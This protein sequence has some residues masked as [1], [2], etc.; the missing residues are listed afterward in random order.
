MGAH[1]RAPII[2]VFAPAS[3]W[4]VFDPALVEQEKGNLSPLR[5]AEECTCQWPCLYVFEAELPAILPSQVESE[6]QGCGLQICLY[7]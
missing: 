5:S 2:A 4:H 3:D 1:F 7:V 6:S